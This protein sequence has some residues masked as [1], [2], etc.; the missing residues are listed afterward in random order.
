MIFN[1]KYE[2]I[3]LINNGSFGMLFKVIEKGNDMKYYALKL[4]NKNL[5][6]EYEKEIETMKNLNNRY[7]IKLKDN[8]YDKKFNGYCI[9]MELC[10]GDLRQILNKYKPKGLPLNLINKI[11]YQLNEALEEMRDNDYIHRDLKPENILIKYTDN[12]KTNFNIKLTDFGTTRDEINSTINIFTNIGTK[13]YMAPEIETQH[14]N[15]KCDLWSLGVIL[16]ELYTNNYIFD[17]NNQEQIENNRKNGKIIK[18][19]DNKMIND[20]IKKLIQVDIK[21]RINWEEY[22]N[23]QFFKNNNIDIEQIIKIKLK[24]N[25][26]YEETKIYCGNADIEDKNIKIFIENK[27]IEFKRSINSLKK[28]IYN[29]IIKINQKITSCQN[30]F[31]LCE[32]ILEIDFSNFDTKNVTDMNS[33]FFSCFSLKN[34]DLSNFNTK[35]VI[36]MHKMFYNCKSLINLNITNFNTKNVFQMES[37]FYNCSSLSNLDI[38]NFD[39]KNIEDMS[40]LFFNCSSLKNLN[41]NNFNTKNVISMNSMFH[42]CSALTNLDVSNFDTKNVI[43]M[44]KMFYNCKLL[45]YLNITNFDTKKVVDMSEMFYNCTSLKNL[46]IS[47]FDF[48]NVEYK[49]NMLGKDNNDCKII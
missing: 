20:L 41:I 37:M 40:N 25:K 8:F 35:N 34:L 4:M 17:S 38:S 30:M 15:N 2:Q 9:V 28:G 12:S 46:D 23:H 33:M 7:I 26:D 21:K 18:E 42:N 43:Y 36:L 31:F 32:N 48:S 27:E 29:I 1:D 19:T 5:S 45:N 24:V 49:E 22:F 14:Y 44:N 11:F 6:I 47:K 13:K 3:E 39:T 10:D 16:Y